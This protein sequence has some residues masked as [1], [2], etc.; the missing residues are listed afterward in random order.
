MF[1]GQNR[2]CSTAYLLDD[3]S[4]TL[5]HVTC[6]L[7][8]GTKILGVLPKSVQ[9]TTTSASSSTD[10]S[11]TNQNDSH[12]STGGAIG[13]TIAGCLFGMLVFH[14]WWRY[15]SKRRSLAVPTGVSDHPE[16]VPTKGSISQPYLSVPHSTDVDDPSVEP[17]KDRPVQESFELTANWPHA[18]LSDR[19]S[20]AG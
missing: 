4:S 20:T 14:F 1:L 8:S 12:L 6:G 19:R 2:Y 3:A 15:K 11:H 5:T 13:I 10:A 18:E 17:Y 7:E 16:L 9:A